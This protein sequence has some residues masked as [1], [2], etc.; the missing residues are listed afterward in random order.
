[1]RLFSRTRHFLRRVWNRG[2]SEADLDEEVQAFYDTQ[3]ERRMA[4][5]QTYAEARRS[6]TLEFD[7]PHRVKERVR[8]AWV[9]NAIEGTVHDI[10]YALRVLAKNPGFTL[11][12]VFSLALGLGANTAIFSL[13]DTV[14]LKPLPV[15]S[16]ERLF[17]VDDTGGKSGGS[18][19]PPYPCYEILRDHNRYFSGLA[20]FSADQFRTTINGV[21]QQIIGQ[22]ASGSFFDVV[23]V[24]AAIGRTLTPAD[25]AEV[26]RG[27]PAGPV[28]VISYRLWE[29]RFGRSP[30][31]LGKQVQVGANWFTIVGVTRQGFDGLQVGHPVEITIPMMFATNNLRSKASWWFS[32]VGRLK[33]GASKEQAAAELD[34]HF[35][36]Y[37][38]E[39]RISRQTREHFNRIVLIPAGR[40]LEEL[41]RQF[42][43][44]LLIVMATSGLVLLIG[45]ANAANLLL[46]RAGARRDEIAL[47]L[48]IGAGR[49]RIIRQLLIEGLLL[50]AAAAAL[51]VAFAKW[52]VTLL[53]ALFAS[54]RARIVLEPHF[55]TRLFAFTAA[56]ALL[57]ALLFSFAPALHAARTD[58]AKPGSGGRTG[59][60]ASAFRAGNVLVVGGIL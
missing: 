18:N 43:D 15:E 29:R 5:G 11:V 23:G 46:A 57:T 53:V 40:G 26:G 34:R 49:G 20:A 13:I 45:C 28:A 17:F 59:I 55:D 60:S 31:V 58:A 19:S 47:R 22:Y 10:R 9:G 54:G 3:V 25:D 42:S 52:G 35:Q 36:T 33:N 32:T 56:I 37:M 8:D 41:R 44:A 4:R 21:Q 16:P 48:A 2:Q 12:A 27:G 38:D 39:V 6:A 30:A 14:L 7:G 1:M 24:G 50:V 51:G